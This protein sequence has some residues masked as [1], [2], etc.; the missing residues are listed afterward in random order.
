VVVFGVVDVNPSASLVIAD[1]PFTCKQ[2]DIKMRITYI[3]YE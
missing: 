2:K 1:N 3:S